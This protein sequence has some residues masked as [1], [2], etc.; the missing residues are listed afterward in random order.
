MSA[1][2]PAFPSS[3]SP[4]RRC[5]LAWMDHLS[6]RGFLVTRLADLEGNARGTRAPMIQVGQ[7]LLRA[8]DILAVKEGR[9]T[10]WEI[11]YRKRSDFDPD[12][13]DSEYWMSY[14]SF[15]D[16][17][18]IAERS[19]VPFVVVLLDRS[20]WDVDRRWRQADIGIIAEAGRKARR[21]GAGGM[22]LE[23][24]VW[25]ASCMAISEGP[26]VD[27]TDRDEVVFPIEGVDELD[28]PVG[29]R[30]L[31]SLEKARR[32][33]RM[34][35]AQSST[36]DPG[37][38]RLSP[39]AIERAQ[40]ALEVLRLVLGIPEY[41]RYSVLC[42][43][44]DEGTIDDLLSLPRYG[45]RLF[46]VTRERIPHRAD[47]EEVRAFEQARLLEWAV[48]PDLEPEPNPLWVVDGRGFEANYRALNAVEKANQSGGING[49]QYKIVHA[50]PARDVIVDAGAGTGKTETMSER[51]LYLL[52]TSPAQGS[53]PGERFDP[54]RLDDIALI[55]FS[56]ES[57][58]ELR[59]RIA[60]TLM[61]RQRLCGRSAL[62]TVAWLTQLGAADVDTIHA[63]ARKILQR[64]GAAIGLKPDFRVSSHLMAFRRLIREESSPVLRRLFTENPHADIAAHDV[65]NFVED[66]WNKL[67]E[68][69][70]SPLALTT[71]APPPVVAWGL[72]ERLT[73][74]A[75][76]VN[77]NL[78]HMVSQLAARFRV[79][80][81]EEQVLPIEELVS[82]ARQTVMA[83]PRLRR[84]P[85]Y[86]FVDEFQDTDVEQM[87]L[88][89]RLRRA[90]GAR[91]YAVGDPKQG[92]YRFRGAQGNA[93]AELEQEISDLTPMR[94]TLTRNFRSDGNLL[95]ALHVWFLRWGAAGLLDYADP[96]RLKPSVPVQGKGIA[97]RVDAPHRILNQAKRGKRRQR[98]LDASVDLVSR[99]WSDEE[100]GSIAVLCRW[101]SQA[102]AVREALRKEGIPCE[103]RVGGH[104]FRSPAVREVAS[105]IQS[106]LHPDDDAAL[107][108]F[109][110]SRWFP[111]LVTLPPQPG[112]SYAAHD[113]WEMGTIGSIEP[114]S[115][116]LAQI[117]ENGRFYREDLE[118]VRK[119]LRVLAEGLGSTPTVSWLLGCRE[120]LQPDRVRFAHEKDDVEVHRYG[121]CLDH[122][123]AVMDASF[124]DMPMS[125]H[126][127]LDW[128]KLQMAT[129]LYEDEPPPPMEANGKWVVAMTVHKAKGLEFDRVLIP[130]AS[131]DFGPP[132]QAKT[133]IAVVNDGAGVPTLLWKWN[134]LE[135]APSAGA[136]WTK[137]AAEVA[138]EE[139]RLLYVAMTRARHELVILTEDGSPVRNGR[140]DD[141]LA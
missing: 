130:V 120:Q 19:G 71:T 55:T 95:D 73:G 112:M 89:V 124:G 139:A 48:V 3:S 99:W 116:R 119:R 110:E 21:F 108:Q 51:I 11:K 134:R 52:A 6:T 97:P 33:A 34:D 106:V 47:D 42:V 17:Q 9:S 82:A 27:L 115:R 29:Y 36:E 135:N 56:R 133:V 65:H 86:I 35:V 67:A 26:A 84:S 15:L 85:R 49:D 4:W 94:F 83:A 44:A 100:P 126:G 72:G 54:L 53:N 28:T 117:D 60:R 66:V 80:C 79:I 70:L 121:R 98:E 18:Q 138:Q 128:L 81:K 20:A 2:G 93:L 129:N 103:V 132:G 131:T 8:P 5:E 76:K 140:W 74:L 113:G 122:L 123:V 43:D 7:L 23:A 102:L 45:I 32:A 137:E 31:E 57:A 125:S 68:N 39:T 13:G 30:Q 25:P 136:L 24:W 69:G 50:D 107:L 78:G 118:P 58:A 14:D 91:L 88:I 1:V 22:E 127:V 12:T 38:P 46:L 104:F 16:Y 96:D 105:L 61:V 63:Y 41:P 37:G 141:L 109:C 64:D 40:D 111:G 77:E 101:N 92:V 114:W 87:D 10:Y 75:G 90:S 59:K 62:P